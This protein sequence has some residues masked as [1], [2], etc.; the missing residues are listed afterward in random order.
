MT[1][2]GTLLARGYF[3]KELPPSFYSDAFAVFASS[4]AGRSLIAAHSPPAGMECVEYTLALPGRTNRELRIPNPVAFTKLVEI[5]AAKF[6]RLLKKGHRSPFSRSA[7]SYTAG[8]HRAIQP[9]LKPANLPRERA[10]SRAGAA[11]VA[12]AD[13]SHF[14]P[15]LYTHAIGWAIDPKLRDRVHW[16]NHRLLGKRVDQALMDLQGKVSQGMPIGNDLSLLF[17]EIVLGEVDRRL[18]VK[19]INAFRW[20]DDYEIACDSRA[21]GERILAT[22]RRELGRFRLRLNPAKTYVSPLP[23]PAEDQWREALL[24][25][26]KRPLKTGRDMVRFFDAAFRV[27]SSYP[28]AP[29]LLYAL[30]ILFKVRYPT[31]EAEDVAISCITQALLAEPGVA[32]KAFAL[33]SFWRTNGLSLNN[34]T[35]ATTIAVMIANHDATGVT[36]DIAWAL[37]F[38]LELHITLDRQS[39]RRLSDFR[40]DAVAIQALHMDAEGLFAGG[41]TKARLVRELT[42]SD[43]EGEHWLAAYEFV[44]QGHGTNPLMSAHPVFA[45]M[46]R[47]DVPFYRPSL[48]PYASL[49]HPGGAPE[50][51]IKALLTAATNQEK[52]QSEF[53]AK[54]PVVA[55]LEADIAKVADGERTF[56]DLVAKLFG[57]DY[58][59][60]L[61][62]LDE[63]Q[64]YG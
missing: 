52:E 12:K 46:L 15:T 17:A 3:P 48:P 19:N 1:I 10:K 44:R 34:A 18:R 5:A 45:E 55:L 61:E 56:D 29:V 8:A 54:S 9:S 62:L 36:S 35:M 64:P 39:G 24:E 42:Q 7:P 53:V 21:D 59:S 2:R 60:A 6:S 33:L 49:L 13:I 63:G 30:G 40:D 47:R 22:L 23:L 58:K 57:D 25:S 38:C 14:Y 37:F 31:G 27:R 11:F 4:R 51:A 43:P 32:Q 26:G 41:F 50:W 28:D 20:Y 16:R